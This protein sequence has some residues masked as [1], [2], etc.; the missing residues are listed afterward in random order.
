[1]GKTLKDRL[2]EFDIENTPMDENTLKI[3]ILFY[4]R[5]IEGNKELIKYCINDNI[6]CGYLIRKM[7]KKLKKKSIFNWVQSIREGMNR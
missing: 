4:K 1:M 5:Q 6:R 3:N 7:K 2:F